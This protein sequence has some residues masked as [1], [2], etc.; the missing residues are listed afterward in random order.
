MKSVLMAALL[1]A[2]T[3]GFA[4]DPDMEEMRSLIRTQ[5][6]Q[7]ELLQQQL[8]ATRES[9]QSL[10]KQVEENAQASE[11]ANV[12]AEILA[13]N[14]ESQPASARSAT[15][16][17]GYGELHL[18]LH[19]GERRVSRRA[20]VVHRHKS[21]NQSPAALPKTLQT[22]GSASSNWERRW[23]Y[24]IDKQPFSSSWTAL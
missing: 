5:Q 10:S 18:S 7:I 3:T 15:S 23:F 4:A 13:E 19:A 9:L 21:G 20:G 1:L 16:L 17:G 12:K 8:D 11:E 6:Q 22:Q 2:G 14:I 24:R